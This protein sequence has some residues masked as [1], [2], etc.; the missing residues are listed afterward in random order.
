MRAVIIA[1]LKNGKLI[2]KYL[3][4]DVETDVLKVYVLKD[5]YE[6]KVS[7]FVKF[8]DVVDENL[9]CKVDNINDYEEEISNLK[10]DIIFVVG[11]SQLISRRIINSAKIGV[12]GFHPSKLPKDRGRSVLAWQI[13]EGYEKGCVSMFWIN[14]GVD[15]GNIIGQE[16][17]IINYSDTIKEVLEKVY[18]TCLDLLKKYYPLIKNKKV[19][20]IKQDESI[21]TY[22]RKRNK[23]DGKIDWSEDSRSIYNLIR[24]ITEPYPGAFAIY[25]GVEVLVLAAEEI[26]YTFNGFDYIKTGTIIGYMPYKGIIV[27]C[28]DNSILVKKAKID[29]TYLEGEKLIHFFKIGDK[30]E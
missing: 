16:E 18:Y 8:D 9:L 25:N 13:A 5:E 20:S 21:S 6:T 24:A 17:Y 30:F 2:T 15:S 7:D 1:G 27:K 26:I 11:W 14:E 28:K 29:G 10:P 4:E 19:T 3:F 23:Y 12:I 22:R